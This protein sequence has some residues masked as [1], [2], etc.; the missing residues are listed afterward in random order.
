MDGVR[1]ST[2]KVYYSKNGGANSRSFHIHNSH[3][4]KL[5]AWTQKLKRL[6]RKLREGF[7]TVE[8]DH[9][10]FPQSSMI[11]LRFGDSKW[12][13]VQQK[14]FGICAP[15]WEEVKELQVPKEEVKVVEKPKVEK[16]PKDGI[17]KMIDSLQ[18]GMNVTILGVGFASDEEDLERMK[19]H[20]RELFGIKKDV[21]LS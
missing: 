3:G 15:D 13:D 14:F 2:N 11:R 9:T 7:D 21:V 19:N 18:V 20:L 6:T 12:V 8:L 5:D 1:V 10:H 17:K 4:L 16:D